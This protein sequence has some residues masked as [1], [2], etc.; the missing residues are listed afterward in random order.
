MSRRRIRRT[1]RRL[2]R[3]A[4]FL[5]R[6]AGPVAPGWRERVASEIRGWLAALTA[7]ATTVSRGE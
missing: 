5:E 2:M 4:A 3:H 7:R 1:V 6:Y